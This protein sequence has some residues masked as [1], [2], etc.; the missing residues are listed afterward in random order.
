MLQNKLKGKSDDG[1]EIEGLG[2]ALDSIST[3]L[4]SI[5]DF[6]SKVRLSIGDIDIEPHFMKAATFL[7]EEEMETSL[8]YQGSG[9]QRAL[10]FAM[11]ECNASVEASVTAGRDHT[12]LTVG[13]FFV[14]A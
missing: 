7:I 13:N 3:T 4:N 12:L 14:S 2:S 8:Q 6:D 1:S 11:L 5:L 10:A 9:V